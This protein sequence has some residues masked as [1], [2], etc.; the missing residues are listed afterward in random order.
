MYYTS[1]YPR[2]TGYDPE[3]L[4]PE[5]HESRE[6]EV[7]CLAAV[8]SQR[9]RQHE[10][11]P[12]RKM[13]DDSHQKFEEGDQVL[14]ARGKAVLKAVRQK[15]LESVYQGPHTVVQANHPKYALKSRTA[16]RSEPAIHESRLAKFEPRTQSIRFDRMNSNALVLPSPTTSSSMFHFF[17][18]IPP[19]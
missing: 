10:N 2:M 16:R 12:H 11:L 13:A 1:Y 14:V 18:L 5:S 15:P 19:P 4:L 6:I 7:A 3:P 8:R 17:M 9:A